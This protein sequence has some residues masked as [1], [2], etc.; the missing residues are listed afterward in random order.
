[1]ARVKSDR[2]LKQRVKD[3]VGIDDNA[4]PVI[5]VRDWASEYKTGVIPAVSL[6]AYIQSSTAEK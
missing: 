5:G 4:P 3:I 6:G 1:M 2:T